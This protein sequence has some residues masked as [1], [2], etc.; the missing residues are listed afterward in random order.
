MRIFEC[1]ESFIPIVD[2][3][4]RVAKA[5]VETL[6]KRGHDVYV[7]T[8]T[9]N[10]GF[11]GRLGYE[12]L[13][14]TSVKFIR[15]LPYKIGSRRFDPRFNERMRFLQPDIVHAHVPATSGLI[16]RSIARKKK[17]PLVGSFHSKYYDDVLKV[18]HSKMFARFATKIIANFYNSCDEVWAVSE[19]AAETLK[20]YGYK[21]DVVVMPNGTDKRD[22]KSEL[23][24]QV[25]K[26]YSIDREHPVFLF[27]GQ[28]NWKKNIRRILESCSILKKEGMTFQLILAGQGPD[29]KEIKNTARNLELEDNLIMTGHILDSGILDVLYYLAD[30]FLF[31]SIYDNAP[32]VVRESACMKTPS[33]VVSGS[34]SAEIIENMRNGLTCEDT[35]ESFCA[36]VKN[37]LSLSMKERD[38]ICTNA[39]DTIPMPWDGMIMDKVEERYTELIERFKRKQ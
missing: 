9:D 34:S 18:T 39:F 21:G 5:Y 3:V 23:I 29:E 36:A 16:G 32:M 31:P 2:G 8:P 1:S 33:L 12:I 20:S 30:I 25:V 37:F 7:V 28:I 13:D 14:Y 11:R 27:V 26:T 6:A 19:N 35:N 17:V 24:P 22:L 10:T 38:L 4:G 15:N